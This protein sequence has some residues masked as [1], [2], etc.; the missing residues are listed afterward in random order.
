[1]ALS[2]APGKDVS[3]PLDLMFE[4]GAPQWTVAVLPANR[5]AS[6]LKVSRTSGTG[7][8]RINVQASAAGLSL[9]A[10]QATIVINAPGSRPQTIV[11]PVALVVGGSEATTISGVCNAAAC[12]P[13]FAPGALISIYGTNLAPARQQAASLPLPYGMQGVSATVNGVNAP[14]WF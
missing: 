5:T 6:W 1:V 3:A 7:P 13:A 9:G 12:D 2:A 14:L 4:D 10:Y 11:S 8:A